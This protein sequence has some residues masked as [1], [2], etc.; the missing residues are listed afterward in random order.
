MEPGSQQ[1]RTGYIRKGEEG[2]LCK[3]VSRG[4]APS[5]SV[6]DF[7]NCRSVLSHLLFCLPVCLVQ[8]T[9]EHPPSLPSL[10]S[11][12]GRAGR[13]EGAQAIP[14]GSGCS[15]GLWPT[16]AHR[17]LLTLPATETGWPWNCHQESQVT[18][19]QRPGTCSWLCSVIVGRPQASLGPSYPICRTRKLGLLEPEGPLPC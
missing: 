1:G 14:F 4:R 9:T 16:C 6:V 8:Y 15:W 2:T 7:E 10:S 13:R 3:Q 18:L 17:K 19:D 5:P 12:A 11:D